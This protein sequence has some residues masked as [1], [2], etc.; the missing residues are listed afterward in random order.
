MMS[1]QT[2]CISFA[3]V[4]FAMEVK[5]RGAMLS[6][7]VNKAVAEMA[8]MV[9]TAIAKNALAKPV[10]QN[11]DSWAVTLFQMMMRSNAVVFAAALTGIHWHSALHNVA[12]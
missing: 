1:T 2:R 11:N 3:Q 6:C 12:N 10:Q 9:T 8:P 7:T 5:T 4:H